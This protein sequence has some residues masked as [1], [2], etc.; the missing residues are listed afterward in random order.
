VVA[1]RPIDPSG[2]GRFRV[3][4]LAT[5]APLEPHPVGFTPPDL[6]VSLRL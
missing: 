4:G 6:P 3:V 2:L 1:I 5:G